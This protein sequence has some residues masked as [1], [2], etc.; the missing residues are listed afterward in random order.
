M[1]FENLKLEHRKIEAELTELIH[2]DALHDSSI[3]KAMTHL[4]VHMKAEEE[5]LF[6]EVKSYLTNKQEIDMIEDSYQE[7]GEGKDF[8]IKLLSSKEMSHD[9]KKECLEC[10]LDSMEHHH[11][12]EEKE[13]FPTLSECMPPHEIQKIEAKLD[14]VLKTDTFL[15]SI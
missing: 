12:D 15:T 14:D 1:A 10:L 11:K 4:Q 9:E 3:E 13:L 6:P 5:I 7:H 2:K 8:I